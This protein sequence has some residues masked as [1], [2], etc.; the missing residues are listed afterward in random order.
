MRSVGIDYP[1]LATLARCGPGWYKNRIGDRIFELK[2]PYPDWQRGKSPAKNR[3]SRLITGLLASIFTLMSLSS[4]SQAAAF[5]DVSTSRVDYQKVIARP[6]QLCRSLESLT[7]AEF[8]V[9]SARQEDGMCRV[10]GVIPREIRFEVN[11]PDGWNGRLMMTGNGGL[12]G[13][14]L[15]DVAYRKSRQAMLAHG[16]ATAY[17]DTG[18]DNRIEAGAS[19]A[20]RSIDK[21]I[22]YGYR[23]IHLTNLAAKSLIQTYYRR[24]SKYNYFTGC[25]NGGRQALMQAQRFPDDFDGILAGA[26][27]NQFTGLKFSQAHRMN[28][29]KGDPL[30]LAEVKVL[31]EHIYSQ[32]D[33][34]DGLSDGLI[35][36]PRA[37]DFLPDRDL[38]RCSASA[39]DSAACFDD[40]EITALSSFYAPVKVAN[41][42]VYPAFPVGSEAEGNNYGGHILPG[43]VPWV[44]NP[45]GR[46]LLDVLG[47]DFFRYIVFVQDDPDYDWSEFDF[48]SEPDNLE[49][50]ASVLDATNPDLSALK[51]NKGKIL[52]YFGWA[53]PDINPLTAINYHREVDL[54][55]PGDV[56]DF[57]R[58]FMVPG[59]FHCSGGPGPDSFDAITP[60]IN[61][62]EKGIAP[63]QITASHIEDS[64][65]QFSR[66]LCPHPKVAV[67]DGVGPTTKASSFRCQ[68]L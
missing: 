61:W 56:N 40:T 54:T 57:Y 31:A 60:L 6:K 41:K 9:V 38:P 19:F 18:H 8:T 47:S 21:L 7:T 5:S 44:I 36:D 29:L 26:P 11:L 13:Q 46:P 66:P 10:T 37:C 51:A 34:K 23:A 35:S 22:D 15:E 14:P 27:A 43:W 3:R 2:M 20:Y 39:E 16:F 1:K 30:N 59:M 55:V 32:C 62:V 4:L 49:F 48:E 12:A 65:V 25:S 33:A 45:A 67:Y 58:L 17:T 52:S 28:A 63:A 42:E 50:T 53:D 68:N 24:P 64:A